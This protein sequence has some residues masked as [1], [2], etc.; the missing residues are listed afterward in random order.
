M[1]GD[2][3]P[4]TRKLMT[5][6]AVCVAL[7]LADRAAAQVQLGSQ[8]PTPRLTVLTPPGARAGATIDLLF[9]GTDLDSPE[10]MLF[11]HPGIKATP[12]ESPPPKPDPKAKPQP[13]GMKGVPSVGK[14]TATVPGDVPPGHYD[15]RLVGKHGVSNPRTF[16]VGA[17]PEAAEKEP[18]NDV[19]QAQRVEVGSTT[20]AA[21]NAPTDVDYYVFKARRGQR[22][23]IHCAGPTI[24]SRINPELK[25]FDRAGSQ[26]ATRRPSPGG[27]AVTDIIAPADGD[28]YVRLCQFT[29]TQ[30]GPDYFYRLTLTTGPWIDAVYPPMVEP[31][32]TAQVTL[33]GRNLPGGKLDP[34][35]VIDGRPL[36]T[37]TVPISAP[38]DPLALQRLGY[39]GHV[40]PVTGMLDGFEYR[41]KTPAGSS[42]PVPV[43]FARAPVVLENPANDSQETAQALGAPCEVAGRIEK[44]R[45]RDWYAFT[46]K[47]GDV[48]TIEAQSQ[49]LGSPTDLF[50]VVYNGTGKQATEMTQLDDDAQPLSPT[51]FYSLSRDPAPYRFVA[52]ADGKYYLL[53][54]SHLG[55]TLAGPDHVYRLRIVPEKPDFRLIVMPPDD[56]RP[57]TCILGQGGNRNLVVL[58]HRID[59]FKGDITLTVDG[60]PPG[61][62]CVPQT[63]GPNMKQTYLVL[64]A[65]PDAPDFAGSITVKGTATIGGQAV[66]REARSATVTW[67]TQPQQNIPTVTRL[68]RSLM[69]AVR[70]KAPYALTLT[71]D[72]VTITHG[73]R[74][75]LTIKLARLQSDFKANV[76]IQPLPLELPPGINF[77][78]INVAAPKDEAALALNIPGN[79]QPGTYNIVLRG[80]G[81]VPSGAKG[82]KGGKPTNVV[83]PSTPLVLTVLPKQVATLSV[84]NP[85][86]TAKA[87]TQ[88]EMVVRVN[89]QYDYAGPFKVELVLPKGVEGLSADPVE[90]PAGQN[91]AKLLVRVAPNAPPGNRQNL[92]I[93]AAATIEGNVA[94]TL[95]HETKINVNVTK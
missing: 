53:V 13:K 24:D 1:Q 34:A 7:L 66:V 62:T 88:V 86:A 76:Q 59:G 20:N 42:N 44:R 69:L 79:L 26:L 30:G 78:A 51:R 54:Y 40:S 12:S 83:Q 25:V 33:S 81:P 41:L 31:G 65:A 55:D 80:A 89:R 93:R 29:Y 95:N 60:L 61:V 9:A 22:I 92:T 17:L 38:A 94:L 82:G 48:F 45:D 18:N 72:K 52:P 64:R 5:G 37:L 74:L 16:V 85:N 56:Y 10:A 14:F 91:E 46:A 67:P 71:P 11:S 58:A 47:K 3:V 57:D 6:A 77:G 21:V 28:Y 35:A 23:V 75:N 50:L 4:T 8:Q 19:D 49:R 70:G 90:I 15:V 27:D 43:F 87:G 68:D 36:E 63:V 32:K 84:A 2:R 39:G 73:D